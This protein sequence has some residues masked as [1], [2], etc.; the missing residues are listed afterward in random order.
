MDYKLIL[1]VKFPYEMHIPCI[2]EISGS[3]FELFKKI[4]RAGKFVSFITK[5]S[6]TLTQSNDNS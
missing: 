4:G 5:K 3:S 2:M 1:F 6:L